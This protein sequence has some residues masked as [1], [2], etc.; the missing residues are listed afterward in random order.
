VGDASS[1]CSSSPYNMDGNGV[2]RSSKLCTRPRNQSKGRVHWDEQAI[3]EH[4]KERGTRMKIDE[5]DTPFVR[6]PQTASDSEGGPASSD[7]EHRPHVRPPMLLPEPEPGSKVAASGSADTVLPAGGNQVDPHMVSKQLNDW[8]RGRCNRRSSAESSS[9]ASSDGVEYHADAEYSRQSSAC[10]SRSSSAAPH[11]GHSAEGTSERGKR[12]SERR[13][14]LPEDLLPTK[15]ISDSFKAKRAQHYNEIAAMKAFRNQV[16]SDDSVSSDTSD[17]KSQ[18]KTNTNTNFNQTI[19]KS[20][21]HRKPAG[22]TESGDCSEKEKERAV[23]FSG[24]SGNESTEEFRNLRRQHYIHEWKKDPS[25][26]IAVSSLETNTNTNR[27]AGSGIQAGYPHKNPM[28]AGRPS[29]Q[30]GDDGVHEAPHSS[31]EFISKRR[32][33]YDEVSKLR[34]FQAESGPQAEENEPEHSDDT[35]P[36]NGNFHE[37]NPMEPRK[38]S[39]AFTVDDKTFS[40]SGGDSPEGRGA[41]KDGKRR[42]SDSSWVSKRQAHYSEMAAALRSMPPPSDDEDSNNDSG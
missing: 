34:S 36:T 11:A 15:P 6:S 27:N 9:A 33:H 14:S 40:V 39:V 38:S 25:V 23:S 12:S 13:I 42:G 29:V 26:A 17:D 24:E 16:S 5:P 4:D 19:S 3:A 1:N 10:S 2:Q 7:D 32:Q 31:D 8:V 37:G 20:L 35:I 30:F 21:G 28:E 22:E 41:T 18:T